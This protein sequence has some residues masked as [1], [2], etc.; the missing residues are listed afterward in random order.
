MCRSNGAAL[1]CKQQI[2]SFTGSLWASEVDG[3]SQLGWFWSS[4]W[5][6]AVCRSTTSKN[7]TG[8]MM[9]LSQ[10]EAAAHVQQNVAER[11]CI[12]GLF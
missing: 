5:T 7:I 12:R 4:F 11:R 8:Q 1:S 2:I 10:Q 9:V 3:S 6:P